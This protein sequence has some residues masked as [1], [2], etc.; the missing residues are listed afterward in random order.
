M[1]KTIRPQKIISLAPGRTCLFG[2][3][4]DYLGLPVIACAVDRHVIL[5]AVLNNTKMFNINMPDINKKR[6]ISIDKK[7]IVFEAGDHFLSTLK[8]VLK[9]GAIIDK[10]YDISIKSNIP[11]NAGASS[12]SAVVIAWLQFLIEAFGIN[13]SITK[14][15]ISKIAYESEVLEH[16]SPG[17]KMDQYSIGMGNV[18]YLETGDDFSYEIINKPINGLIIGESGV[19][20]ETIGLLGELK[21]KAW[22][23]INTVKNKIPNFDIKSTH[24]NDLDTYIKL[25]PLELK[26]YLSAA[27]KNYHITINALK[28]FKKHNLSFET[29]GDLMN[30]HHKILKNELNITVPR[31]DNMIDAALNAGALGAKIVGSGGGGSI[32]VLS[33]EGKEEEIIKAIKNAGGVNAYKVNVD[34][35]AR[36]LK[37]N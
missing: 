2:D 4:Q 11:I 34:S 37:E 27:I 23:A 22:E 1:K 7:N 15:L 18:I 6:Q 19:P 24:I 28:E 21:T 26:P 31:I 13:K 12:S 32:V 9:Y 36:I 16:N 29:I 17:G 30:Q 5:T 10:G 20:K 25:V 33:K 35:G 14:E 3:H 8:V